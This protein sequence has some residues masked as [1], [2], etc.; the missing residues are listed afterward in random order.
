MKVLLKLI[1]VMMLD[2]SLSCYLQECWMYSKIIESMSNIRYLTSIIR[3]IISIIMID[4]CKF[5]DIDATSIQ[6]APYSIAYS[7]QMLPYKCT[8]IALLY[9]PH[10]CYTF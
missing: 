2:L 9:Y 6:P 7:T 1:L 8:T 3:T 10:Y 4:Y 5:D